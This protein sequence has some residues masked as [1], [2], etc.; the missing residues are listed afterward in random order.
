MNIAK[1]TLLAAALIAGFGIVQAQ[2]RVYVTDTRNVVATS[3]YDLCWRTGF[4]TPAAAASDPAGC[5]CDRD[6]LPREACEAV[7]TPSL[8]VA[9]PTTEKISIA[10]DALFDFDKATLRP[11][12]IA[13]LNDLA[14]QTQAINLEVILAVG[15]ADRLGSPAYNQRL[16]ERRA[17]AVREYLISQGVPG[18][19][20]YTEG[21]GNTQSVTGNTC[22]NTSRKALIECLQPD[23]R[24]DIELIGTR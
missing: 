7:A 24:V 3:G 8:P 22:S 20:I 23:R 6:L 18:D 15:H 4:W 14:A 1:K 13:K 19:R 5:E 2:E 11:E 17:A 9:R 21:K 10:A 12:G 16:S